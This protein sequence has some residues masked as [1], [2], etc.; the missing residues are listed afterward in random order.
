MISFWACVFPSGNLTAPSPSISN[1]GIVSGR[2]PAVQTSPGRST[3]FKT[4]SSLSRRFRFFFR[5][6]AMMNLFD[7]L[8]SLVQQPSI[9]RIAWNTV[10][11]VSRRL[12]RE[13]VA[14]RSHVPVKHILSSASVVG[15]RILPMLY[16]VQTSAQSKAI[17]IWP[18]PDAGLEHRTVRPSFVDLQESRKR[19]Q[20]TSALRVP[21]RAFGCDFVLVH[22]E[23][24]FWTVCVSASRIGPASGR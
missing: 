18:L 20:Q 16:A 9:H 24:E 21:V 8:G 5:V 3:S 2:S 17:S 6:V 19:N 15:F 23:L 10:R 13:C 4:S 14:R 1:P 7:F 11:V 22:R 12:R